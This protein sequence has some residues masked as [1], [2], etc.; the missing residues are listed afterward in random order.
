MCNIPKAEHTYAN[1]E[2]MYLGGGGFYGL[3]ICKVW[4]VQRLSH[5]TRKTAMMSLVVFCPI[6]RAEVQWEKPRLFLSIG[7]NPTQLDLPQTPYIPS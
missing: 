7:I 4:S 3:G 6:V 2:R 5:G 1:V